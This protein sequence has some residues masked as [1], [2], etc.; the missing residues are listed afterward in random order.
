M[1]FGITSANMMIK[2]VSIAVT[3]PTLQPNS[4]A[5]IV[6]REGSIIF[7]RLFAIRM[8]GMNTVGL[9]TS[10]SRRSAFL[11]PFLAFRSEEHTSELQSRFDLVCRLLLE[12]KKQ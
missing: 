8:T 3:K 4:R 1:D 5:T 10:L 11:S 6:T 9:L 2:T 7:G 12:K